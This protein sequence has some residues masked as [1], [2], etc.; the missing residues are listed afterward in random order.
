[1]R[2]DNDNDNDD[3]NDNENDN[4]NDNDNDNDNDQKSKNGSVTNLIKK[5]V[6]GVLVT[7]SNAKITIPRRNLVMVQKRLTRYFSEK[8]D[9]GFESKDRRFVLT[10]QYRLKF[11]SRTKEIS[12]PL[13]KAFATLVLE[14]ADLFNYLSGKKSN[15]TKFTKNDKFLLKNLVRLSRINISSIPSNDVRKFCKS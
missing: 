5:T 2:P 8:C 1:M 14:R 12:M 10:P 3:D 11:Q 13:Y 9:I 4:E 15:V 7:C 6:R